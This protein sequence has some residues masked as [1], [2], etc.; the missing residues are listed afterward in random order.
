[1]RWD[2]HIESNPQILRGKLCIKGT[3]SP[4]ALILGCLAAERSRDEFPWAFPGLTGDDFSA[5]LDYA[6]DL[7]GFNAVAA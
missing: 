6:R 7:A 5:C 2:E 4:V 3:R 1:M